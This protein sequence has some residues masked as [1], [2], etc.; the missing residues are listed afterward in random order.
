M[1]YHEQITPDQPVCFLWKNDWAG[2][3]LE[4]SK[5]ESLWGCMNR[6]LAGQADSKEMSVAVWSNWRLVTGDVLQE[7]SQ[8]KTV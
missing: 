6:K 1:I 3:W 5:S 8:T 4:S 7:L 2:S